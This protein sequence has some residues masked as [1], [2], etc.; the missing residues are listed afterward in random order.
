MKETRKIGFFKRLKMALFELENYIKFVEEKTSKAFGF[1]FKMV[2]IFGLVISISSVCYIY[3][4]YKSPSNYAKSVIPEFSYSNHN[5]VIAEDEKK[6]SNKKMIADVM[7]NLETTYRE[8]LPDGNNTKSDIINFI[9]E[10]EKELV[11]FVFFVLLFETIIQMFIFWIM[12]ALLTSLIG[13]IILKFSRI[14][15]KYSRLYAISIYAST[16]SMILTIVYT[17]LNNYFNIYIDIFDYLSMLIAY[18]YITAVIY[19]IKS[20]LIKQQLE[21]IKIAT[22]QAKIKEQLENEKEKEG[23]KDTDKGEEEKDK[24]ENEQ[25][26]DVSINDEPDGSEI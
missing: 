14:K 1:V 8:V 5:L 10:N 9:E 13:W 3:T 23:K 19:M 20:D 16:L 26:G 2:I 22:V 6:D 11:I 12:V 15:M 25:E 21:L 24:K 17:I 4:K 7:E 18:V